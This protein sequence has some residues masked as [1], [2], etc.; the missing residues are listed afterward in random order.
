MMRK[1]VAID[2]DST[3]FNSYE[4]TMEIMTNVFGSPRNLK[5]C[6]FYDIFQISREELNIF[7]KEYEK[8]FQQ[9]VY[10]Y[11]GAGEA[12]QHFHEAG[13]DITFLT[14]RTWDE[15]IWTM[16]SLTKYGLQFNAL[17]FRKEKTKYCLENDIPI[18]IDDALEHII[19]A[20]N[21]GIRCI[22]VAQPY[23]EMVQ[24]DGIWI[25]RERYWSEIEKCVYKIL[26]EEYCRGQIT[27]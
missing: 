15:C 21:A 23:N 19:P 11:K 6:H 16:E 4:I 14:A 5:S 3:I 27:K 20:A 22:A 8:D 1:A 24:P 13:I 9:K 17:V 18:L 26:S 7:W 2:L 25:F 12:L 10:P